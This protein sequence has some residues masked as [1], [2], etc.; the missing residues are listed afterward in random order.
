MNTKT[1][2]L[3]PIQEAGGSIAS[4]GGK[5]TFRVRII[6][7]G[8]GSSGNYPPEVLKAAAEARVFHAGTH[9][10]IDHPTAEEAEA[11]PERS[12]RTL[13]GELATDAV[14]VED[15]QGLE[16]EFR[17]LPSLYETVAEVMS[18]IGLSIRAS[19]RVD[20][21][22]NVTEL[23]EA[24]SVDLV[25]KAGRGG[26]ILEVMESA[27]RDIAERSGGITPRTVSE[28]TNNDIRGYLSDAVEQAHETE[29]VST[30]LTDFDD[31]HV[32]FRSINWATHPQTRGIYR[33]SY[34]LDG[35][36]VS[37]SGQPQPVAAETVYTPKS[38]P[39]TNPATANA[40]EAHSTAT[41]G[42]HM[43]DIQ[44]SELH[45]LQESAGR[46]E[47]LAS[48]L[49]ESEKA[50]EKAE[51]TVAEAAT[52]QKAEAIVAEAFKD[53]EA[54]TVRANLV[55]SA[56]TGEFDA[57]KFQENAKATAAEIAEARNGNSFT[58]NNFGTTAA[59]DTVQ[60]SAEVN[61]SEGLSDIF[62]EGR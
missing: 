54:P 17:P 18:L 30:W 48:Q 10:H 34:T 53:V 38:E 25:T 50:R 42:G 56:L 40:V 8:Q 29:D 20:D 41:A 27:R 2:E 62:K 35:V 58:V 33:Q 4:A 13:A 31:S 24:F 43:V 49:A 12:V 59:P 19:A 22:D 5:G 47:Q 21:D 44:E 1:L 23:V 3:R 11:R 26:K 46:A 16:A 6:D 61:L 32:Y 45:R 51:A 55:E 37:L 28:A 7:A 36:N 52:R 57:E 14:W 39:D 9:F 15:A 60:E